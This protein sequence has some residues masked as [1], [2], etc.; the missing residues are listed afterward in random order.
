MCAFH[1]CRIFFFQTLLVL[2]CIWQRLRIFFWDAVCICLKQHPQTAW[3]HLCRG[4]AWPGPGNTSLWITPGLYG[5][6]CMVRTATSHLA[7][8]V[9]TAGAS[10]EST[11]VGADFCC[12][13]STTDRPPPRRD[14]AGAAREI[15]S[16]KTFIGERVQSSFTP[17][18]SSLPTPTQR[19]SFRRHLHPLE[20]SGTVR[21]SH[22]SAV[23][24]ES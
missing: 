3:P 8:C 9:A 17:P 11:A 24:P 5:C 1:F 4:L 10:K 15:I 20:P 19:R 23:S 12:I 21:E 7:T 16:G 13:D 14:V 2:H 22:S 18:P 6:E